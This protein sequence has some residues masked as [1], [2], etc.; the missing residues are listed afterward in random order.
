M[1]VLSP[2]T[3]YAAQLLIVDESDQERHLLM[4]MLRGDEYSLMGAENAW[5]AF[6]AALRV[7]PALIVMTSNEDALTMER[8][9]RENPRT[10]TIP[11]LFITTAKHLDQRLV[12]ARSG[13]LD[14]IVKP[15]TV[16][17]LN[18]RVQ[19]Q[20]R[21][22]SMLK[23]ERVLWRDGVQAGSQQDLELVRQARLYLEERVSESPRLAE[24]AQALSEPERHL[25]QVF[26][27]CMGMSVAQYLR[28]IRMRKAKHLLMHSTLSV[29]AIAVQ[30]GFSS[31][32]NF[33]TAFNS[34]VGASPSSFRS[35]VLSNAL[36]NGRA[37]EK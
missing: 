2:A 8:R 20:L 4:E 37:P 19:T 33:S 25:S 31:A 22:S 21:L 1:K 24:L 11:V 32:A 28:Q 7:H 29:G 27:S 18:Q 16:A 17:Q 14:Y 12:E 36:A 15:F 13:T 30:V 35:Q 34:W 3:P 9:L 10:E 26:Q 5:Q 6:E 23:E